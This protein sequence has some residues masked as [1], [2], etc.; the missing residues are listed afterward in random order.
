MRQL[1]C[2]KGNKQLQEKLVKNSR[3]SGKP[4]SND[5]LQKPKPKSLREK[6]KRS[7]GGQKR[8]AEHRLEPI[9][10]PDEIVTSTEVFPLLPSGNWE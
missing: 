10:N 2:C 8:H 3:N 5:G 1:R 6:G 4:P 9:S 7:S